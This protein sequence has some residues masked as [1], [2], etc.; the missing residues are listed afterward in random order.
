MLPP[1]SSRFHCMLT[2]S[3]LS[4]VYDVFC[5]FVV[6]VLDSKLLTEN[7]SGQVSVSTLR[8]SCPMFT[9]EE[10]EPVFLAATTMLTS[11]CWPAMS[12]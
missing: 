11:D 6:V 1:V 3:P 10:A 9:W 4:S 12:C 5:S 2:V 7:V 8:P